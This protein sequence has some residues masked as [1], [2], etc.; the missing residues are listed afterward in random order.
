[1]VTPIDNR[2]PLRNYHRIT[3]HFLRQVHSQFL[4]SDF[5][6]RPVSI[7]KKRMLYIMLPRYPRNRFHKQGLG[8]GRR[9][10]EL[11]KAGDESFYVGSGFPVVSYSSHTV[12]CLPVHRDS[13]SRPDTNKL[14]RPTT[15]QD[16]YKANL[17]SASS[18]TPVTSHSGSFEYSP[19]SV[20][21][22]A[23]L[24]LPLSAL[25]DMGFAPNKTYKIMG[26]VHLEGSD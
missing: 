5:M 16:T 11:N 23:L 24:A 19:F 1:M 18:R 17:T 14:V 10:D 2:I 25:L 6:F 21:V 9:V 12:E 7:V 22:I 8:V 15:S 13:Y 4:R 26:S 20:V 3:D